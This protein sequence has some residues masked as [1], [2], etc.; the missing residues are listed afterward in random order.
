MAGPIW[1]VANV[2]RVFLSWNGQTMDSME[3]GTRLEPSP[4][5][6]TPQRDGKHLNMGATA[7][8][9]GKHDPRGVWQCKDHQERQLLQIWPVH[10]GGFSSFSSSINCQHS[11]I[12]FPWFANVGCRFAS[13]RGSRLPAASYR[14][15]ENIINIHHHH[16]PHPHPHTGGRK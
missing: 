2:T 14:S 4:K 1:Y 16:H 15:E 9:W 12:F 6:Q 13:I 8:P 11:A 3:G 10:A 5:L 7:D